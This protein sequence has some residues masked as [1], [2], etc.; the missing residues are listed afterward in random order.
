MDISE[1]VELKSIGE[2][3]VDD[4]IEKECV[5]CFTRILIKTIPLEL[6]DIFIM[7]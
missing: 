7:N 2:Y 3:I 1:K 6:S 4:A 5:W